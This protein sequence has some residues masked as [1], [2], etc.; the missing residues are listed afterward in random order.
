MDCSW[1]DFPIDSSAKQNVEILSSTL[2][3]LQMHSVAALV[4]EIFNFY[5]EQPHLLDPHLEGM[6]SAC[7]DV[8]HCSVSK[9]EVF[10]FA[11]RILYQMTKTR[12]YKAIIRL[13]P[14]SVDDIE[15]NLS[16]LME[17]K[18]GTNWKT[19]YIL[20]LWL[21]ILVMV[22]FSLSRLDLPDKKPIIERVVDLAKLHLAQEERTQ[23]A[24]AYL[25]A[26]T[27]T[28]PDALPLIVSWLIKSLKCDG[29]FTVI[30]NERL[31]CGVLRCIA[32]ICKL[33][34]RTELLPHANSLLDAIL[35]MSKDG[36][37]G[38]LICHLKTKVLQ[39]VG[40]LFCPPLNTTWRYY[41][42]C[43]SLQDNLD[44]PNSPNNS[45]GLSVANPL[46]N[47]NGQNIEIS[48]IDE[49]AEVIDNLIGSLRSQYTHVRWSAAKIEVYCFLYTEFRLY[50]I[51]P[52]KC[53][54]H[55]Q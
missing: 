1:Q 34:R 22:P 4:L 28:R 51:N 19:R 52:P 37:V 3:Y 12:G 38:V 21:S 23:E 42:G 5:Q 30:E 9:P 44:L 46:S 33:G 16:L 17:Q 47:G 55:L 29:R 45:N 32:N 49:V 40:L 36:F 2:R 41:R 6:I 8:V 25:L 15:P 24:A 31:V 14:H 53:F 7:L 13:M 39:R 54:H 20:L 11:F 48:N 18:V 43:R 27:V 26:R 50:V 35:Q 10:H